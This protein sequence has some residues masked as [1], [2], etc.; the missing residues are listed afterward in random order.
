MTTIN[1]PINNPSR[2]RYYPVA[3]GGFFLAAGGPGWVDTDVSGTT[4]VD[5]GR[6]WV[7]NAAPAGGGT[8]GARPHGSAIDPKFP[9]SAG[10]WLSGVDAAGHMDLYQDAAFAVTYQIVGYLKNV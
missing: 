4:G 5:T 1:S 3:A 10:V 2:L 8:F 6:V 9:C 7:V